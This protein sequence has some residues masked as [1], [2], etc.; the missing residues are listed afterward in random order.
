MLTNLYKQFYLLLN[1]S[2][3]IF[4]AII[5]QVIPWSKMKIYNESL[6]DNSKVCLLVVKNFLMI[7]EFIQS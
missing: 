2:F 3:I 6:L 4:K 1:L 5:K 7:Q